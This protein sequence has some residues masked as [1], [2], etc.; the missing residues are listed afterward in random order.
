MN[1]YINPFKGLK[2]EHGLHSSNRVIMNNMINLSTNNGCLTILNKFFNTLIVFP[3][4]KVF[5]KLNLYNNFILFARKRNHD[6]LIQFFI[7][8]N[9]NDKIVLTSKV[10]KEEV[11]NHLIEAE[12]Y[13]LLPQPL[14]NFSLHFKFGNFYNS[15]SLATSL[16]RGNFIGFETIYSV[17]II[18]Y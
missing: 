11:I 4:F 3:N 14:D 12:Y 7:D 17:L 2:L 18:L 1:E 16:A 15:V 5:D 10:V 6:H 9:L 8:L 13:K